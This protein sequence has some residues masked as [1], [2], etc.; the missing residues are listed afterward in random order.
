MMAVQKQYVTGDLNASLL[1]TY[2]LSGWGRQVI[3]HS[4][5]L[6][7]LPSSFFI[8]YLCLFCRL[9]YRIPSITY[10]KGKGKFHSIAGHEGP[11][12]E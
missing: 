8:V 11:E 12:G 7:V 1:C 2:I 3:S 10:D 6:P 4:L 9:S 5:F